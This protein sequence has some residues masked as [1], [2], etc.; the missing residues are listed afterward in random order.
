MFVD[1]GYYMI[2]VLLKDI[3][4][5]LMWKNKKGWCMRFVKVIY[6]FKIKMVE[7]EVGDGICLLKIVGILSWWFNNFGNIIVLFDVNK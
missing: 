3:S 7:Y 4:F 1:I 5:K 2:L 6:Y